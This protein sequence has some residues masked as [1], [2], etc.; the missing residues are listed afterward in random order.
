MTILT[1][2][3]ARPQFVKAA[4]VSREIASHNSRS[5]GKQI[6]E[7]IL[8]TGQHYDH[9]MSEIFFRE[10][11]IPESDYNL[12]ISDC[13]HGAMTGRMLEEIEKIMLKKHPQVV[14]V[15]GDTNSTLAGALAAAKLH[16]PI[17]H[18]EAGLRCFNMNVPEE[19]N[20]IL[21]DHMSN[22]LFCPTEAAISN[23]YQEGIGNNSKIVPKVPVVSNVGDVMYDATLF[24]RRIAKASDQIQAI[25]EK[26][27][28]S[29]YLATIHRPENTDNYGPLKNIVDA[30]E[31]IAKTV[32]IVLPL[33]PRT[34]KALSG[35]G[36]QLHGVELIEPVGY[37]DMLVL[38]NSCK[39]VITD[40]GGLQKEA[41]FFQ[42]PCIT[43]RR[44]TE[45][46]ELV[47]HGFNTLVGSEKEAIIKAEK[48]ISRKVIGG[49]I[50]VLYGQGD[51]G[52]RVVRAL[53][54]YL[55]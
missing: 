50:P 39:A 53:V 49:S 45:W 25:I 35:H 7:I 20:R 10:M 55:G 9:N 2:I 51:A 44:E 5:N 14:L 40:S 52:A 8:H 33:H 23:L 47:E 26:M 6:E 18:V 4:V 32:P 42:K 3:G 24:Y 16:I 13:S 15:Y 30:M 17:A 41:Y 31:K 34:R 11:H 19:I 43:L 54:D 48:G 46:V 28:G 1:I 37:F 22:F 38:L 27:N 36:L 12:G 29:Y 21:T